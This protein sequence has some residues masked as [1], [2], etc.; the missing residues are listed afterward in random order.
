M[1]YTILAKIFVFIL[2]V[3]WLMVCENA[4]NLGRKSI[5]MVAMYTYN[6]ITLTYQSVK[7][8]E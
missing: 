7:F 3:C 6:S 5:E 1:K 4:Y 8:L 2:Q